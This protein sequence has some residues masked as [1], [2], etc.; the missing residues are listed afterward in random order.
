MFSTNL[1][2]DSTERLGVYIECTTSE[3]SVKDVTKNKNRT[4]D[5]EGDLFGRYMLCCSNI[6]KCLIFSEQLKRDVYARWRETA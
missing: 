1:S 3:Q 5:L 2:Y 6:S 4:F